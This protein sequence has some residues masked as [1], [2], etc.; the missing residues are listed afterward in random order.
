MKQHTIQPFY[1]PTTVAFVDD[2]APFLA[3]LS[4]QLNPQLAFKLFH[5]SFAALSTLNHEYAA[6]PID[7][8]LFSLYRHREDAGFADH[9]IQVSLD[10]IHREVHNADRFAQVSVVVVDYDMPEMNGLEFCHQLKNTAIKKILLTGK[11]DEQLAVQAFNA[12]TIDRFIRKQ[13]SNAMALL[14]DAIVELQQEYFQ[15]MVHMLSRTLSMGT[16]VFLRDPAVAQRIQ[17]I[18][19]TLGIVEHYLACAPH[20]LLMF[21]AAGTAY[22]LLV[23]DAASMHEV[24]EI[25]YDQGAPDALLTQL[26]SGRCVPYFWKTEGHYAPIY[27]DWQACLHPATEIQGK[28]GYL[29]A[30]LKNPEGFNPQYLVSYNDY[31]EQLDHGTIKQ[32]PAAA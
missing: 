12:K 17:E 4:L 3:N 25:A 20:G 5:S 24:Y 27:S 15:H 7:A 2:S 18:Q 32:P 16:H 21:D 29:Y 28:D 8:D 23:Q 10:K 19:Q 13:D 14:N 1:F 6:T 30:V 11:A 9:V 26:R 22:L 31:L